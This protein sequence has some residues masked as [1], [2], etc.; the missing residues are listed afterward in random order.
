M[1]GTVSLRRSRIPLVWGS[2]SA[3]AP[4]QREVAYLF[5]PIELNVAVPQDALA[6][7]T[8]G[9]SLGY[10]KQPDSDGHHYEPS[11]DDGNKQPLHEAH[12]RSLAL[13]E[14]QG[15]R[16]GRKQTRPVTATELRVRTCA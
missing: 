2:R 10:G 4:D 9:G 7:A 15:Q 8:R 11:R 14:K 5:R 13:Y 1:S 12:P 3:S 16:A 6:V